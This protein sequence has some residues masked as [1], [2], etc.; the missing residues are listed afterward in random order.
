MKI[1]L[2]ASLLLIYFLS[3]PQ[4]QHSS[5]INQQFSSTA[6]KM[7]SFPGG[8]EKFKDY[9][10]LHLRNT[11]MAIGRIVVQFVVEV[12]GSLSD[13][14]VVKGLCSKCD[15]EAIRVIK[16]S[17]RWTPGEKDGIKVRAK[18]SATIIY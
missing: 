3:Y 11:E 6:D 7:P 10:T 12:D 2:A 13:T 1:F 17:P 5:P 18:Y 16:N 14:Q 4:S 9:I 8:E 15:D